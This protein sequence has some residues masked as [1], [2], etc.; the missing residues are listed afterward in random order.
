LEEEEGLFGLSD[1]QKLAR[2]RF[3]REILPHLDSAYTFARWL[4][5]NEPDAQDVVQEA[6]LRALRF[7]DG[8]R[9]ENARAW[10][11]TIVRN[12][13]VNFWEKRRPGEA[14]EEF[15]EEL[16]TPESDAP[17]AEARLL[18][19]ASGHSVREAL[20]SIPRPFREALIL[21]EV[22]GLSYKEIGAVANIPVGTVMSRLARGRRLLREHL[23]PS[24]K[25]A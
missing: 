5:G 11:L 16:H 2:E 14:A 24:E 22:E 7:F 8:Y 4:T 9:G 25:E 20:G 12:T 23:L 6:L 19:E 18:R 13:C 15:D 17:E 3:E 10:L 1:L 21:R